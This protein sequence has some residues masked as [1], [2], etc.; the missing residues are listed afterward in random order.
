MCRLRP[1]RRATSR[2]H[3]AAAGLFLAALLHREQRYQILPAY[4]VDGTVLSQMFQGSTDS[5][6]L[7]DFIEQLL[8]LCGKWPQPTSVILMD[9]ASIHHTERITQMCHDVGV[10]LVYLPP[11][12]PDLNPIE[13]FFAELKAFIERNWHV[14]KEHPKQSFGNFLEWCIEVVRGG[15]AVL[16]AILGMQD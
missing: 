12:S 7:E 1:P 4:A 14:Y 13:E 11:Y 9:N 8:P 16:K 3:E 2:P 5:I 10:K 6:V 15:S